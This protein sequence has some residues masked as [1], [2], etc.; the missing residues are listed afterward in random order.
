M[1]KYG[2]LPPEI[3]SR[4]YK[5]GSKKLGS[6]IINESGD[7]RPYL[8]VFEH[9]RKS[10]E[11]NA[12]VSFGTLS[13]LEMIHQLLWQVEPNYSDRYLAK[14]S[15]T[16]P[17][18]GNTPRKVSEAIKDYGT[19][20]ED[21]WGFTE[22]LK[23]YYKAIPDSIKDI[24][25]EW[26]KNYSYGWEW[27]ETKD[28]KEALKRSPVGVAVYAWS[29]NEKGEYVKLGDP[30]HWC[31][32]VAFDEQ[33]RAVVWDSYDSGLKTLAKDHSLGFPQIYMLN[34]KKKVIKKSWW[35][36][37]LETIKEMFSW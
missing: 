15:R 26:T 7:W 23:E 5:F 19:V 16:D 1:I 13:A 3:D 35:S 21:D 33:N 32:L 10:I 29:E 27:T 2:F 20:P 37:L 34:R 4:D 11:T 31:V 28:L 22:P 6:V 17:N 30:N 12:C 25:K 24:G 18:S 9:Q 8:P 36:L 14:I